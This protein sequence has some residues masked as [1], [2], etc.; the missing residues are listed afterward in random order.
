MRHPVS[1]QGP[2]LGRARCGE[3]ACTVC[4]AWPWESVHMGRC[5]RGI[6]VGSYIVEW[7]NRWCQWWFVMS[8]GPM[9]VPRA[10]TDCLHLSHLRW[11]NSIPGLQQTLW[12][13]IIM[14]GSADARR[15]TFWGLRR[16]F[17]A[18]TAQCLWC[19]PQLHQGLVLCKASMTHIWNVNVRVYQCTDVPSCD[20]KMQKADES[21]HPQPDWGSALRALCGLAVF[22]TLVVW[23]VSLDL[24]QIFAHDLVVHLALYK[25]CQIDVETVLNLFK[26]QQS[27]L[28]TMKQLSQ[29]WPRWADQLI[30]AY[31]WVSWLLCREADSQSTLSAPLYHMAGGLNIGSQSYDNQYRFTSACFECDLSWNLMNTF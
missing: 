20:R 13:S 14:L 23:S 25:H 8:K 16:P 2:T 22:R 3:L 5:L 1:W 6:P 24:L 4:L 31:A 12:R 21:E 10:C 18:L 15:L 19:T 9:K 17:Q 29:N 30:T 26:R 11:L 27:I 7:M 28:Q